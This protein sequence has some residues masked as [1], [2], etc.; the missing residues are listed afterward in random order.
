MVKLVV[1]AKLVVAVSLIQ[2]EEAPLAET[3]RGKKWPIFYSSAWM[4]T[5][6]EVLNP[7]QGTLKLIV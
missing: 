4:G 6:D 5:L 3:N 1:A 7:D 2:V